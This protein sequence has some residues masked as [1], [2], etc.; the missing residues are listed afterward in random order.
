MKKR[1]D[2]QCL[3][4]ACQSYYS[5]A[6]LAIKWDVSPKT[7]RRWIANGK[8]HPKRIGGSVRIPHSE[9]VKIISNI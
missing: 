7:V 3:C 2:N 5:I 6:T 4:D 1:T 9:V 8:L